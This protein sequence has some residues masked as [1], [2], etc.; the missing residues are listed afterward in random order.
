MAD[1]TADLTRKTRGLIEYWRYPC[2][3]YTTYTAAYTI[4]KGQPVVS[5]DSVADGYAGP[6][7]AAGETT[8]IF[9]GIAAEQVSITASDLAQG[10]KE[11]TVAISGIWAF[12]KA[13]LT[14]TDIG[15]P[16][17]MSDTATVTSDADT[18]G[19]YWIGYLVDVDDTFAWVNIKRAAGCANAAT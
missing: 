9:L 14:V 3:G 2:V 6:A 8:D 12:P 11:I 4:Y 17:Y 10:A 5:D 15:A 19:N 1:M 18:G 13:S 16:I 7:I